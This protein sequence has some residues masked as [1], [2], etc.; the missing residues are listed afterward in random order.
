MQKLLW[1]HWII[2]ELLRTRSNSLWKKITFNITDFYFVATE[3]VG[4]LTCKKF[5]LSLGVWTYSPIFSNYDIFCCWLLKDSEELARG[6]PTLQNGTKSY[7]SSGRYLDGN[8][9]FAVDGKPVDGPNQTCSH[10]P[11][12][13]SPWWMVDLED[14]RL[15]KEVAITPR[16]SC[17][18]HLSFNINWSKLVSFRV[19]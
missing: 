17:N 18:Y 6:K 3:T 15:I 10:T 8:S 5:L 12:Y 9:S 14:M 16:R 13:F 4:I 19:L 7:W 1:R 11:K 2:V